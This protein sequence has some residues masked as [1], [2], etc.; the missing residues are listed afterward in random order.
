MPLV[1]MSSCVPSVVMLR[2]VAR[3]AWRAP[4]PP[5]APPARAL[6]EQAAPARPTANYNWK[7][8]FE[9]AA[10]VA[11]LRREQLYLRAAHRTYGF[12]CKR[13]PI[14]FSPSSK[15]AYLKTPKA[16]SISIQDLFQKQF[17]DFRWVTT[18]EPLPSDAVVFT[19]TRE[20]VSRVVAAYAEIDVAYARKAT[21]E[22]R[23]AMNTTFHRRAH[24][25][26]QGERRFLAF[27]DDLVEQRF[28]GD[29]RDHWAPTHAYP[30]LNFACRQQVHFLGRLDHQDADWQRLQALVGIPPAERTVIP[31]EHTTEKDACDQAHA[32][33]YKELDK[34]LSKTPRV[35]QRVCDLFASDFLCLGYPMPSTCR[36]YNASPAG[37]AKYMGEP[38]LLNGTR[39]LPGGAPDAAPLY[40]V[41][42]SADPAFGR[43][44]WMV[45]QPEFR[46]TLFIFS[47]SVENHSTDASPPPAADPTGLHGNGDASLRPYN[48]HGWLSR[49]VGGGQLIAPLSAGIP[50]RRGGRGFAELTEENRRHI[51]RAHA[52]IVQLLALHQYDRVVF[53]KELFGSGPRTLAERA[54]VHPGVA[55][56]ILGRLLKLVD[57]LGSSAQP[58]GTLAARGSKP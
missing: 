25:S 28:G 16:A 15:L 2:L 44:Q 12:Y 55:S 22:R 47:D 50:T 7:G 39:P 6:P 5:A 17:P 41:K 52:E 13:R 4:I 26:D 46:N 18:A 49:R 9:S 35:M 23:A 51:D 45:K 43:F 10:C 14:L 34:N 53:S 56:Y 38:P 29:D 27:L 20:P 1:A 30:Q 48:R 24:G 57:P 31:R 21:P 58:G 19:F 11:R 40:A 54:G 33:F 36:G 42:A 3:T 32:C 8:P 37:P